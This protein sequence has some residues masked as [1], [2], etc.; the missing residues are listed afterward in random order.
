M[1]EPPKFRWGRT[2]KSQDAVDRSCDLIEALLFMIRRLVVVVIELVTLPFVPTP[3]TGLGWA[4]A[5][6]IVGRII[7]AQTITLTK[8]A[9]IPS[10][11]APSSVRPA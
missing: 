7:M 2:L 6:P 3:D 9:A 10:V 5:S 1:N 11:P 8:I 4:R